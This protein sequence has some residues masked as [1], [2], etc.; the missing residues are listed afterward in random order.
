VIAKGTTLGVVF[1]EQAFKGWSLSFRKM[2][3]LFKRTK[4][5]TTE[6]I[7]E[8]YQNSTLTFR[9]SILLAPRDTRVVSSNIPFYQ[10]QRDDVSGL[11]D[12]LKLKNV[13]WK[14][15]YLLHNK[16][17]V[18][19]LPYIE[20]GEIYTV[21]LMPSNMLYLA[22]MDV[23]F[24]KIRDKTKGQIKIEPVR[25]LLLNILADDIQVYVR[26]VKCKRLHRLTVEYLS[27]ILEHKVISQ[28][29]VHHILNDLVNLKLYLWS[30]GV[31]GL[32]DAIFLD[33]NLQLTFIPLQHTYYAHY[34]TGQYTYSNDLNILSSFAM[35]AF[36]LS[37]QLIESLT[38]RDWGD[39]LPAISGLGDH[40]EGLQEFELP[41]VKLAPQQQQR[42]HEFFVRGTQ[43]V[44]T[45][46]NYEVAEMLS[47][48]I[49]LGLQDQLKFDLSKMET[50]FA[51]RALAKDEMLRVYMKNLHITKYL[52]P[53]IYHFY[54]PAILTLIPRIIDKFPVD[55][56]QR[57][58]NE[59]RNGD[60]QSIRSP[61]PGNMRLD[62]M[63]SGINIGLEDTAPFYSRRF[64]PE[65]QEISIRE[66]KHIF[67]EEH[68]K[69]NKPP[70]GSTESKIVGERSRARY[71]SEIYVGR[72]RKSIQDFISYPQV[73][74]YF[75]SV[76]HKNTLINGVE[77]STHDLI[78]IFFDTPLFSELQSMMLSGFTRKDLILIRDFLKGRKPITS[79][80]IDL[81][82]NAYNQLSAYGSLLSTLEIPEL[83]RVWCGEF[84]LGLPFVQQI[85]QQKQSLLGI[86]TQHGYEY[87]VQRIQ[88]I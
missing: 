62:Y 64:T 67:S 65:Q 15:N 56:Y 45:T 47:T 30:Q 21:L 11:D 4:M 86:F 13:D 7:Y 38:R 32:R 36:N 74:L 70:P 44:H 54:P 18:S 85:R 66:S 24:N 77:F 49:S 9:R 50:A 41:D 27:E 8:F 68:V 42:I 53:P 19:L 40:K 39:E 79:L 6:R 71:S 23:K 28:E 52:R 43:A 20:N 80:Y 75:I 58:R 61:L 60:D 81:S 16:R 57:I 31:Q 37:P 3:Y 35:Q 87:L 63:M 78:H 10:Y 88:L 73:P 76:S 25:H 2:F 55:N 1:F 17:G 22:G 14:D 29:H 59:W 46:T 51:S 82:T 33:E 84:I 72:I 48:L 83:R 26:I 69:A 5:D 34:G 12:Y